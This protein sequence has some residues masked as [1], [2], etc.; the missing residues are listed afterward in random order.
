MGQDFST[1]LTFLR[2]CDKV[3]VSMDIGREKEYWRS[4]PLEEIGLVGRCFWT[5]PVLWK[6]TK[7]WHHNKK[8]IAHSPLDMWLRERTSVFWTWLNY[9]RPPCLVV[10]V[11]G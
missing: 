10:S 7:T 9:Y 11:G 4:F 1:G 8:G 3:R 5:R 2:E 6:T